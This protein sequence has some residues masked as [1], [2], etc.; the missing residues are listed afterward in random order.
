VVDV[1][2]EEAPVAQVWVRLT[3]TM[4]ESH[5]NLWEREVTLEGMVTL[6]DDSGQ[7]DAPISEGPMDV[8]TGRLQGRCGPQISLQ[9]ASEEPTE[10]P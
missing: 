1:V 9:E 7:E 5:D 6:L 10:E 2:A 3:G 8:T 4:T